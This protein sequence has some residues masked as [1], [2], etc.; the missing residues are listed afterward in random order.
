MSDIAHQQELMSLA[1]QGYFDDAE[2]DTEVSTHDT[3]TTEK[4]SEL[5]SELIEQLKDFNNCL[6]LT[7]NTIAELEELSAL[8]DEEYP[9][10]FI[11]VFVDFEFIK[12]LIITTEDYIERKG[13]MEN[14]IENTRKE[15][16]KAIM[17][18]ARQNQETQTE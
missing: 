4:I 11:K 2:S 1:A 7:S 13:G 9:D 12:Q 6:A 3:S 10:K 16:F 15:L 8:I 18:D 17:N 5:H 14:V